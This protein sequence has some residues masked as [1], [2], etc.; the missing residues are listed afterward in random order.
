MKMKLFLERPHASLGFLGQPCL[1]EGAE[2]VPGCQ[3]C[4]QLSLIGNLVGGVHWKWGSIQF[5]H[6]IP[7]QNP[8]TAIG[9][10]FCAWALCYISSLGSFSGFGSFLRLRILGK[11]DFIFFSYV[12]AFLFSLSLLF[13][14]FGRRG[15][16][17]NRRW[18]RRGMNT[19]GM[20]LPTCNSSSSSR[21]VFLH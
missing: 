7:N 16:N 15:T 20:D 9:H 13:W 11:R 21:L 8:Y 3:P 14:R 10:H 4:S 6:W 2:A 5:K 12:L 18:A 19:F 1:V 17:R